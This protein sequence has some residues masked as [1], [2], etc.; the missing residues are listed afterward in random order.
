MIQKPA[1]KIS[2][3]KFTIK[4]AKKTCIKI[5][6]FNDHSKAVMIDF[7]NTKGHVMKLCY[8]FRGNLGD[9]WYF[10]EKMMP[11]GSLNLCA[12]F[13]GSLLKYCSRACIDKRIKWSTSPTERS[14]TRIQNEEQNPERETNVDND[15]RTISFGQKLYTPII[16][17]KNKR[18]LH[19]AYRIVH[20]LLHPC[21]FTK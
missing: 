5:F 15:D 14:Y 7:F 21:S 10:P 2:L 9:N 12:I 17:Q 20:K 4:N 18:L 16:L 11:F 13:V 3:G 1:I 19:S 8:S 6:T